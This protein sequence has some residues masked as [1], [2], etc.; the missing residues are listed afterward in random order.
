M[1][2]YGCS[3]Y[4]DIKVNTGEDLLETFTA[5]VVVEHQMKHIPYVQ[6]EMPA[7]A[8]EFIRENL[9]SSPA[10]LFPEVIQQWPS[11]TAKQV[12]WAWTA[13]S[14][15]LWRKREDQKQSVKELMEELKDR[16]EKWELDV[17]DGV[18]AIA[19]GVRQIA[20]RLKGQVVEIAF[21]ATCKLISLDDVDEA[22]C[23]LDNTNQGE[24]E[25]YAAMAEYD[26]AGYPVAYLLL[27]TA[28]SIE[29]GKRLSALAS[30]MSRI[31]DCYGINPRFVH[32]D[33]DIAEIR[34]AKITWPKSKHQLCWWHLRKAI[35]E[36]L[37]TERLSTTLYNPRLAHA[38]YSFI[39]I[40]FAPTVQA[41]PS[42]NEDWGSGK[43]SSRSK[44][45]KDNEANPPPGP[46]SANANSILV[47]IPI[48]TS[49]KNSHPPPRS[50]RANVT[51]QQQ[52]DAAAAQEAE[53]QEEIEFCPKEYRE[54]LVKLVERHL[55]MHPSIPGKHAPTRQAIREWA[56]R[57]MFRYCKE[58]NL[59][60]CWAYLWGNWYQPSQW[61]LWARCEDDWIPRLRT[62]MLCEAQ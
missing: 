18:V 30:F 28:S 57:E 29:D 15:V 54:G 48:P 52:A 20:R 36:R 17:P 7:G 27:S 21:D 59:R 32:T 56:A 31:R 8:S 24:L 40:D 9:F 43:W 33:K 23:D 16:V 51:K 60:S 39:D 35:R 44:A 5:V 61:E 3:G 46:A 42:T 6:V 45:K 10:A 41:G 37:A 62:T 14:E 1:D 4:L 26:N 53:V 13:H 11:V 34:A 50:T 58:R 49:F 22:Y 25:L 38:V 55:N 2:R 47:R 19:W 12:Y